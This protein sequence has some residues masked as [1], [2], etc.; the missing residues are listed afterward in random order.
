MSDTSWRANYITSTTRAVGG[1][2][3]VEG[4][5]VSFRAHAVDRALA[6]RSWSAPLAGV[7]VSIAPRRPLSHL[8]LAGLRRQL[9][10]SSDGEDQYFIVNHVDR[11]ADEIQALVVRARGSA[12][13]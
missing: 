1:R 7:T 5:A 13:S 9:V 8:F 2:L 12:A 10:L 6:G 11:V 4:D 3:T